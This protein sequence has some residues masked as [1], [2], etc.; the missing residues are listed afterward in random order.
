MVGVIGFQL[1]LQHEQLVVSLVQ[2]GS[3]RYHDI[4]LLQEETLVLVHLQI[5][6]SKA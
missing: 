3:Q 6:R 2:A 1:L 5:A 4:A